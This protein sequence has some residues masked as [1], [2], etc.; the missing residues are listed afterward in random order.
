LSNALEKI[1]RYN[2]LCVHY[3]LAADGVYRERAS[4][5]DLF[6][7]DYLPYIVAALISFDLGRMM[8]PGPEERYDLHANGF[9]RNFYSKLQHIKL[10]IGH[11]LDVRLC[12][13]NL[14]SEKA[15]IIVAYDEL[16][17]AGKNSLHQERKQFHVGATKILH[18]INPELF[19]II[20]SNTARAF[21]ASHGIRYLDSTQPGYSAEKYF[22]CLE[23]AKTDLINFGVKEFCSLEKG[24]PMARI[25]DKLSWATGAGWF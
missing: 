6:G 15:N 1:K 19:V 13:A 21:R 14:S 8:G 4:I 5:K 7:T 23:Y 12:N 17:S 16:A 24:S 18:F 20:D 11:L 2:Q 25:Y 9:A 22:N 3:N 10:S